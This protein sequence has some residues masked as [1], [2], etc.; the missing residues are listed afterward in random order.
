M[1]QTVSVH[2]EKYVDRRKGQTVYV[3]DLETF[4]KEE[5]GT[6]MVRRSSIQN[7]MKKL[8]AAGVV[9]ELRQGR[10]WKILEKTA[11]TVTPD[12]GMYFEKVG[13]LIDGSVLLKCENGKF[14]KGVP[15]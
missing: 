1:K 15:L 3:E 6:P 7:T 5:N 10:S 12:A 13:E 11:V 8:I 14:Y 4:V 2:V 9:T